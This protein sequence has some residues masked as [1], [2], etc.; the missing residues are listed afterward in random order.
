MTSTAGRYPQELGVLQ[1]I[2]E[3]ASV[4][5][6]QVDLDGRLLCVNDRFC[7]ITGYPR[8]ELLGRL[9]GTITHPDDLPAEF[10]HISEVIAG[11][12][13]RFLLDKRY[14]RPDGSSIWVQLSGSLVC[15]SSGRP[16][17]CCGVVQDISLQKKAEEQLHQHEAEL[18]H[19]ARLSTMGEMAAGL[20]HE[21]NQPLQALTNYAAGALHRL[22]RQGETDAELIA[23]MEQMRA[24]AGRAA[25]IV[26]RIRQFVRKRPTQVSAVSLGGLVHEAVAMSR[27]ELQRHHIRVATHLPEDLPMVSGDPIEIEQVLLNLLRNAIEAMDQTP[28]PQRVATLR[29]TLDG[30]CVRLEISDCGHG[31]APE[32]LDKVFEPFF[33]TKPEGMG[34]GLA[35]SRSIVQAHG[36]QLG[37]VGNAE[38]GCTFHVTLPASRDC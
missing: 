21:L 23:V 27:M 32:D 15:D 38:G 16:L 24:E 5:I 33:T 6:A 10:A 37:V 30:R 22:A 29:A 25:E 7:E 18:A 35:I 20:A 17:F 14:V 4:G 1:A 26:R 12:I 28:Q 36:G 31:I 13:D 34:M 19:V 8:E 11:K 9:V 2:F 3:Q